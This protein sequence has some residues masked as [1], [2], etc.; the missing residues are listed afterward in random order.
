MQGSFDRALRPWGGFIDLLLTTSR[1]DNVRA[2]FGEAKADGAANA[3][4]PSGYDCD[5]ALQS[6]ESDYSSFL[7]VL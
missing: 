3:G 2:G 7:Q 5:F 1:G 6:L 4:R